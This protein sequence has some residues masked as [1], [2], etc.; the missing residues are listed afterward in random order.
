M[1]TENLSSSAGPSRS[2][3][4]SNHAPDFTGW[5]GASLSSHDRIPTEE[6]SLDLL[7][8]R[9]DSSL[10]GSN[11]GNEALNVAENLNWPFTVFEDEADGLDLGLEMQQPPRKTASADEQASAPD[12]P[13]HYGPEPQTA[14]PSTFNGVQNVPDNPPFI[15]S[16][17]PLFADQS[18]QDIDLANWETPSEIYPPTADARQICPPVPIGQILDRDLGEVSLAIRKSPD[19]RSCDEQSGGLR[20][21]FAPQKVSGDPSILAFDPESAFSVTTSPRN[22]LEHATLETSKKKPILIPA[23]QSRVAQRYSDSMS[24][25]KRSIRRRRPFSDLQKRRETGETRRFG[26]CVRCRMQRIRVRLSPIAFQIWRPQITKL[27][28]CEASDEGPNSTCRRC[29]QLS[30]PT[31]VELPCVRHKITDAS[32]FDKGQHPQY[33][34]S[35]RWSSWKMVEIDTW[36]SEEIKIITVTQDVFGGDT[37]SLA[38]REFVPLEGDS[39]S[40][41]WKRDGVTQYYHRAPYAIASMKKTAKEIGRFV[42]NNIRSSIKYYIDTK[43]DKLLQMTYAMG[44]NIVFRPHAFPAVSLRS[45]RF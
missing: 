12:N 11:W 31:L 17:A 34:W 28:Q 45:N 27:F 24:P 21:T 13:L 43:V 26:A 1:R 20:N 6:G 33:K 22:G 40:R 32:L 23:S 4:S 19:I 14:D 16:D 8:W 29:S 3:I 2:Q 37:F 41:M 42:A 36:Q 38:C 9:S 44:Y 7:S 39:L 10:L 30:K 15:W 18:L 25:S 5:D 35:R